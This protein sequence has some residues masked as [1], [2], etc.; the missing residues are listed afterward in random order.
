MK[1]IELITSRRESNGNLTK[2][3]IFECL[4]CNK[5]I[6]RRL[7][8]GVHQK[9]CGCIR[10][11][12]GD[13]FSKLYGVWG[14]LLNRCKNKNN[15][16][17]GSRGIKVCE[18]WHKYIPFKKWACDNGYKQGLYLDRIDNSKG[19]CPE[20]CRFVTSEKSA[21]NRKTTK[22]PKIERRKICE[23][24]QSG[25]ENKIIAQKYNVKPNTISAIVT[26]K[27]NI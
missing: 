2:W 19:Y 27:R 7:H 11:K 25:M 18:E 21:E 17:Y 12:H 1:I 14:T 26:G 20:N 13:T 24:R 15:K 22:I 10:R 3:A 9:S 4:L 8:F 6:E 5:K 23:L 16:Y